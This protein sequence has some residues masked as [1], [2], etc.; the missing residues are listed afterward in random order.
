MVRM[1]RF[2]DV[3]LTGK[4]LEESLNALFAQS[5]DKISISAMCQLVN[6]FIC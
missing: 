4:I 2:V 5:V 1:A 6:N 3:K